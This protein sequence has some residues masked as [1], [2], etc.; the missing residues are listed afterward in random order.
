MSSHYKSWK[1]T[2]ALPWG[3]LIYVAGLI[4]RE[5]GAYVDAIVRVDMIILKPF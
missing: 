4:T 3:A 2:G 1:M 5:V